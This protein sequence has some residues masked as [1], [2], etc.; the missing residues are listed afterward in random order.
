MDLYVKLE[1]AHYVVERDQ[2]F[3]DILCLGQT[4]YLVTIYGRFAISILIH[5][6]VVQRTDFGYRFIL[7]S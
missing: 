1:Q 2:M 3:R 4:R 6:T 5:F 7:K